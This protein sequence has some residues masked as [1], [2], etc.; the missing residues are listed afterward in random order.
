M[1]S[2]LHMIKLAVGA[3]DVENLRIWQQQRAREAPPLR[4]L[5]RQIPRR[6]AEVVAGGSL[7]WVVQGAVLVRQRILDIA[8][9]RREDGSACAALVLDTTLVPVE[10]RPT[11]AF[12]GWRYLA[13]E[14]APPDLA[15][16]RPADGE[17]ALPEPMR[18]AL[19]ALALI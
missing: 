9:D 15:N 4:H 18:R 17:A 7:Y 3:T 14:A 5:T 2:M 12:Q 8:D 16:L 10:A 6:A 11:R 13:P 1:R 19:R